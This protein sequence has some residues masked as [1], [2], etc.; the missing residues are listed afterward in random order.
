M[1]LPQG[2]E[3]T[4]WVYRLP[5][6][7]LWRQSLAMLYA[8]ERGVYNFC[9]QAVS[10]ATRELCPDTQLG[11]CWSCEP[12]PGP[13]TP[14]LAIWQSRRIFLI[15]KTGDGLKGIQ[16][17]QYSFQLSHE[18]VLA[19]AVCPHFRWLLSGKNSEK[20][21]VWIALKPKSERLKLLVNGKICSSSRFIC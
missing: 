17:W 12:P 1:F 7:Q 13:G 2:F 18:L 11:C 16:R 10:A 19:R 6:P 5:I 21:V 14:G 3:W 4:P 8:V 20:N 9:L 15:L